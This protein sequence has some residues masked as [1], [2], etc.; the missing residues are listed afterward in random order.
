MLCSCIAHSERD[1]GMV[2]A[3]GSTCVPVRHIDDGIWIDKKSIPSS[4]TVADDVI[5]FSNAL[6]FEMGHSPKPPESLRPDFL[7]AQAALEAVQRATKQPPPP[8]TSVS[9]R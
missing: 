9:T 4:W 6:S 5:V 1:A 7:E 3:R 2:S 8:S